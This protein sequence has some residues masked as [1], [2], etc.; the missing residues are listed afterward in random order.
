[1]NLYIP[2]KPLSINIAW[3]GQRFKT[4]DY[5]Q[6]ENDFYKVVSRAKKP[7]TGN[8]SVK[9]VFFLKNCSRTD[10][11]NL[12]KPTQDLLVK[13]GYIEDDRKIVHIDARKIKSMTDYIHIEIES[14]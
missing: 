5:K 4:K 6:Y 1:M 11:D 9:Y 2:L 10:V 3:Q 7:L 12:I 13:R 14:V 8:I